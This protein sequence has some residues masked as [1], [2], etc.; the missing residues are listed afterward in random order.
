M[1]LFVG[2]SE[3]EKNYYCIFLNRSTAKVRLSCSIVEKGTK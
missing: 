1:R 3:I 2:K